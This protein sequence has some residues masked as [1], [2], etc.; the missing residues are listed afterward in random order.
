MSGVSITIEKSPTPIVWVDTSVVTNMTIWRDNPDQLE[1]TQR[2]R[3]GKLFNLIIE[4]TRAGKVVCPAAEQE[5]EV[6]VNREQ[7][8][9]TMNTLS[10]GVDCLDLKSIQDAQL[11][12]AM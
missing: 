9:N 3:I 6:W 7:W 8:L 10:M 12:K 2:E 1:S 5:S 4:S 11:R